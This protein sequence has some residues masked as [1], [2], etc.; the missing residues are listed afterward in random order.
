MSNI[1]RGRGY[2][3]SLKYHLVCCTKYRK[4]ILSGK[5]DGCVKSLISKIADDHGIKILEIETD[6]DHIHMLI[7]CK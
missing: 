2:V 4:P 5:I 6:Q 3:Y 1:N 7:D